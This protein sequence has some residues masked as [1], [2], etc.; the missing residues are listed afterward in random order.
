VQDGGKTF[1]ERLRWAYARALSRAPRPDELRILSELQRKHRDE[2]KQDKRAARLLL[3]VGMAPPPGK[4][5][6]AELAGWT[7][8]ARSLLSLPELITRP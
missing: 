4:L 1:D 8:V 3:S 5:D 7:S 2:Y 6:D